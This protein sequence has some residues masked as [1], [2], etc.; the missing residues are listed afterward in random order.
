MGFFEVFLIALSLAMDAFAVSVSNGIAVQSIRKRDCFKI[1]LYFGVFQFIMPIIGY[2]L[3]S[4]FEDII[5]SFDHWIA[6]LLLCAIGINMLRECEKDEN[7]GCEELSNKK[8]IVQAIATSIDALAVGISFAVI[9]DDKI[10]F[11]SAVIGIVA[12]IL[13]FIG[14]LFGKGL[15]GVFQKYANRIGGIILICIGIKILC[16]H[17]DH[18]LIFKL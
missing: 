18:L 10:L 4:G 13:S 9:R 1:A 12:L 17:F 2:L 7:C 3:A 8:L 15:G 5:K 14:G 16:E 11:N 6:F